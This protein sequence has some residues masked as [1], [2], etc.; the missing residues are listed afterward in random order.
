VNAALTISGVIDVGGCGGLHGA[1]GTGGG[2]GG[3]GGAIVLEA[4]HVALSSTAVLAANGGGGGSGDDMS[5]PGSDANAST[6]PAPGGKATTGAGGDGGNGGASNGMPGQHFTN[7]R[8][9]TIPVPSAN[10]YGGGG[11]G[12]V[13]RIAIRAQN[14]TMGGISDSSTAV[15]PDASD[16]NT[17][18]THPTV[19]GPAN[20][21]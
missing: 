16:V 12:G 2:G 20:F 6:V 19:Y 17:A 8:D 18:S 14:P 10:D 15:T 5:N 7:G 9:G 11:G 1:K 21:Q 3:A 13:G 4:V